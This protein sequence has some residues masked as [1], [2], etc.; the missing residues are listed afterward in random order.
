MTTS[1]NASEARQHARDGGIRIR[2]RARPGWE[3]IVQH[4]RAEIGHAHQHEVER[5]LAQL[6]LEHDHPVDDGA[7]G[8]GRGAFGELQRVVDAHLGQE[9]PEQHGDHQ[10]H[11][12]EQQAEPHA[13]GAG[14]QAQTAEAGGQDVQHEHRLAF[15]QAD[16]DE[17]VAEV[18]ATTLR[19]RATFQRA[20]DGHQGGV[21]DRQAHHGR[22]HQQHEEDVRGH[23]A[24]TEQGDAAQREPEEH[25]ARITHE[26][27]GRI[28]VVE[29]ESERAAAEGQ[30][31]HGRGRIADRDA[32]REQERGGDH[33]RAG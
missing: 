11:A 33:R 29:Q 31:Q 5:R 22:R 12:G 26:D 2:A 6:A 16:G 20:H 7:I 24:R 21:E 14:D 17:A 3:P 32:E 27:A 4:E 19:E 15:A 25:A 9:R 18:I 28:E 13:G 1:T 23:I 8:E 30:A 10:I